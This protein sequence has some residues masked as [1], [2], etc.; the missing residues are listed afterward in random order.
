MTLSNYSKIWLTKLLILL[1]IILAS[2]SPQSQTE[3]ETQHEAQYSKQTDKRNIVFILVD[4]MGFGDVGYNGSEI[5][6]PNLDKMAQ[7][8]TVLNRNY[9]YPICSP[10]RAALLTGRSPLELV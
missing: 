6:T 9:V 10:T 7:S 2:C 3:L 1:G 8:G 5:A 4:D